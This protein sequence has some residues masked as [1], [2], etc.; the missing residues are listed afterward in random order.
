MNGRTGSSAAG[1]VCQAQRV[2]AGTGLRQYR[3]IV[4]HASHVHYSRADSDYCSHWAMLH[5]LDSLPQAHAGPLVH[6]MDNTLGAL[7]G[8]AGSLLVQHC[9][10]GAQLAF[11]WTPASV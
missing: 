5:M 9:I 2:G 1:C 6:G 7:G 8:L 3:Q 4:W 11:T 10:E